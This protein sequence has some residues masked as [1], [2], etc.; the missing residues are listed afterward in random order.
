MTVQARIRILRAMLPAALVVFLALVVVSLRERPSPHILPDAQDLPNGRSGK[1]FQGQWLRDG[2]TALDARAGLLE[3]RPGGGYHLENVERLAIARADRDPLL[4]ERAR[5]A[6]VEGQAGERRIHV[7]DEVV[8]HDPHDD[9]RF[10]LPSIEVDEVAGIAES[11]GEV[12]LD[13]PGVRGRATGLRYDL[14]GGPSELIQPTF[15]D[16]TG[17]KARAQTAL[18]H[19]G[20]KDVELRGAVSGERGLEH[21]SADTLHV[22]RTAEGKPR[23]VE[24]SGQVQARVRTAGDQYVD[25]AAASIDAEWDA[26]G[27]PSRALLDRDASLE[28]QSQRVSADRIEVAWDASCSCFTLRAAGNAYLKAD[29]AGAPAWLSAEKVD[30]SADRTFALSAAHADGHV[31]FESQGTRAE[32][33]AGTFDPGANGGTIRL[34]ALEPRK[35]RLARDRTRVAA[36]RIT[37]DAR[38]ATLEAEDRVEAT[39]LPGTTGAATVPISGLFRGDSAVSFV[40]RSLRSEGSGARVFLRDGVRGWQGERSLSADAVDLDQAGRTLAARGHVTTRVP[41][42]SGHDAVAADDYLQV[43][44]ERLDYDEERR[45]GVYAGRVRASFTEGWVEADRIQVALG[46]QGGVQAIDAAGSVRIEFRAQTAGATEL[47]IGTGDRLEYRPAEST[48][49][50]F[51]DETPASVRRVGTPPATTTG[52]VLRYRLDLGTLEVEPG[53]RTPARIRGGSS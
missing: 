30:A 6:D 12:G 28:R 53:S 23:R 37:T 52:R 24:S 5:S 40:A 17:G 14:R 1:G 10:S 34:T 45:V 27:R 21:F 32:A 8:V 43:T 33:D 47:H 7:R 20:V 50:L 4:V 13:G 44:A 46:Q 3:E 38:G 51:G 49:R 26:A 39:L 15:E 35:A 36:A 22:W 48:V 31:R 25:V 18:L 9:L 42:D 41:R 2:K 16:Q 11:S 29:L 19:D